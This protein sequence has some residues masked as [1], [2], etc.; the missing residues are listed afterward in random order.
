MP[1][2]K[3]YVRQLEDDEDPDVDPA[4]EHDLSKVLGHLSPSKIDMY[5]RCA[6]QIEWRYVKGLVAL[7]GIAMVEG[8]RYHDTAAVRNNRLKSGEKDMTVKEMTQYFQDTFSD[9]L[10]DGGTKDIDWG[11]GET[12]DSVL[13]R[14]ERLMPELHTKLAP[15]GRPKH[16]EEMSSCPV[17]GIPFKFIVDLVDDG[18]VSDYKVIGRR[19]N[20]NDVDS[21]LQLSVYAFKYKTK[22]VRLDTLVKGKSSGGADRL[23]STRGAA[24]FKWLFVVAQG[25]WDAMLAGHFPPCD[26]T[27]WVCGPKWCGYY[28]R[29]RGSYYSTG[30]KK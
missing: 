14:A 28:S 20:Q 19:K 25:V 15:I 22:K 18:G 6:K 16:V 13:T 2:G 17:G 23:W 8:S 30:R 10:S 11:E 24:D 21:S 12:P 1:A 5:L 3:K 26:P 4:T 27:S 29:C 7:P 9:L